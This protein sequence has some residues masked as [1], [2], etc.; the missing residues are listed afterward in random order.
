MFIYPITPGFT[1]TDALGHI[2]NTRVPV[3]FE[4]A[5]NDVFRLFTP[6]LDPK[7]WQLI[8]ARIEVDFVGELFYGR[9]VEIRTWIERI[10]KSSFTVTQEAWQ[11]DAAGASNLGARGKAILVHYNFAEGASMPLEGELRQR[12]EQHLQ[13]ADQ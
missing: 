7:K 9:D 10:G 13:P 1:D 8:L 11:Q 6:D 2:N 5:R 3:W 4:L 12:L